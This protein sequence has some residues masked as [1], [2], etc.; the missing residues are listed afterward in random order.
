M[1]GRIDAGVGDGDDK[2]RQGEQHEAGQAPS[3]GHGGEV[4]TRGGGQP[5]CGTKENQGRRQN[6]KGVPG[7]KEGKSI[8]LQQ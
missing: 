4:G 1:A 8:T 6:Q 7:R 3:F 5:S 2:S